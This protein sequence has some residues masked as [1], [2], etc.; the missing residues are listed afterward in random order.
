MDRFVGMAWDPADDGRSMRVAEWAQ[1]ILKSSTRWRSVLSRPGL[2]VLAYAHRS[3]APVITRWDS[4]DGVTVGCLFRAGEE[5]RARVAALEVKTAQLTSFTRGDHL[6]SDYWGGYVAFWRDPDRSSAFVLRD[7]CGSVPCFMATCAGVKLLFAHPDDI[8]DL[9]GADFSIDWTYL[10]AFIQFNF[11][12][13]RHT[14]LCEVKELMAGE[15]LEIAADGRETL[16]W[17][18]NGASI[19]ARPQTRTFDEAREELRDTMTRC[20]RALGGEYRTIVARMSGGLDSSILASLLHRNG[21]HIIGMH[22]V[23]SGYQRGEVEMARAAAAYIGIE[24]HEADFR[25]QREDIACI[26]DAPR[27]ARPTRQIMTLPSD[28]AFEAFTQRF[29]ADCYMNG[30]GG[31]NVLM[32]RSGANH[33]LA[34]YT[35][36][37]GLGSKFW[38]TA[39][40]AA[41]LQ[42]KPIWSVVREA[43][44][45]EILRKPWSPHA[46]LDDDRRNKFRPLSEKAGLPLPEDYRR[47]PWFKDAAR[48]P[49]GKADHLANIVALNNYHDICGH[50]IACDMRMPYY[51]QPMVEFA[52]KT[53]TYLFVEGGFDR[54]LQRRAFEDCIPPSI[55]WR[56][57]KGLYALNQLSS[58]RKNMGFYRSLILD[59]ELMRAGLLDR[60]KLESMLTHEHAVHG[61]GAAFIDYLAATEAWLASWRRTGARAAA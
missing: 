27:L 35:R 28:R 48:L 32:Q 47:H 49:H 7:P 9:P 45:G 26:L 39:Y 31:D 41:M 10:N 55:A 11:F 54:S 16:S 38:Q 5:A 12:I 52:L 59:G 46:F 58:L 40:G 15:R 36:L 20:V 43:F 3:E 6:V 37:N 2:R 23:S 8:A 19:A 25:S 24:L 61:G 57:S 17:A 18:W 50:S 1:I 42:M 44:D 13:S 53:P 22:N 56:G 4:G 30:H 29:G 21:A 33:V 34:D 14:G 51:S 60:P